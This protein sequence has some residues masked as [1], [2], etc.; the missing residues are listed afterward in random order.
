MNES[1]NTQLARLRAAWQANAAAWTDIVRAGGIASRRLVT[2][3]A[4]VEKV[5]A[6]GPVR[7]LDLGCGEGWLVRALAERG[8]AM[9]GVDFSAPL[10]K[11]AQQAGPGVFHV[12]DYDS[13]EAMPERCGTDFDAII[14]NFALLHDIAP[15]FVQSLGRILAPGG[16]LIIQTLHPSCLDG[17]YRDGWRNEDFRAFGESGTWQEMPWYFRTIGSWLGL[18]RDGGFTVTELAEPL[19]P[20]TQR[21]LSLLLVARL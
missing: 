10:I 8:I 13:I 20:E 14:A 1:T 4:I 3:R 9:T 21:P 2:D 16:T 11:A 5:T 17:P 15:S 7:A 18:L 19:H 12:L 6:L